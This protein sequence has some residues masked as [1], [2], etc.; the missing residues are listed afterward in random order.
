[1]LATVEKRWGLG[2]LTQRDAAAPDL[3][4]VLTLGQPRTDDP[5]A[6]VQPPADVPVTT[7]AGAVMRLDNAPSHI[8]AV[9]ASRAAKLP[10]PATAGVMPA[11][12]VNR[13]ATSA[14]HT[15]FI[16]SRLEAWNN[17]KTDAAAGR[18]GVPSPEPAGGSA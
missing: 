17:L 3:G 13:L 9:Y 12:A 8:E 5:L 4:S 14:Q 2:H 10:I 18:P 15:D 6:G 11:E 7:P 16:E 1:M